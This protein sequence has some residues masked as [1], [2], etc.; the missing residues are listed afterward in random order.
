MLYNHGGGF[1]TGSAAS[2][3]QDGAQL[4]RLYDVVVVECKVVSDPWPFERKLWEE[5]SLRFRS[6]MLPHKRRC[7]RGAPARSPPGWLLPHARIWI[8]PPYGV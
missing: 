8:E 7:C 1:T 6:Q 3:L 5:I 2:P 4:A